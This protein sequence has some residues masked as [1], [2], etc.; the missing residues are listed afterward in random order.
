MTFEYPMRLLWLAVPLLL[1]CWEVLH[2]RRRVPLPVDGTRTGPKHW[3]SALVTGAGLLPAVLLA[4][5]IVILAR[6][7][8]P[9]VPR[10][11]RQ[12]TNVELVMDVSGSMTSPFGQGTRFDGSMEAIRQFTSR[13]RGD[14]FGLTI[15]GDE[16][17]KWTPLTTDL[18]A[19]ESAA[20]WLRPESLPGQFGGT[21][22][23]KAVRFSRETLSLRG[24][25]DR[26]IILISDGDSSD[27]MGDQARQ[28]AAELVGDRIVLYAVFVGDGAPPQQLYD[29]ARPAGG[30]VFM[31]SN[32]ES[33]KSIFE[34]I[35]RMNPVKL[36]PVAAQQID[37]SWPFLLVGLATLGAFQLSLLGVRFTPW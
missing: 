21:Q 14:A 6:P 19:I 1:I 4:V 26:A 33:L 22:A 20:P 29:L 35:D 3:L 2:R 32:P 12:L 25:G 31:A 7:L 37:A 24:E 15:F 16:V 9:D 10:Q 30:T 23:G 5:A 13:R 36:K 11:E 8:K 27:L 18:A 34:H 17:L 28:I